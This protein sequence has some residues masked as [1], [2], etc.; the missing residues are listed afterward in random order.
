MKY[1][2]TPET[3]HNQ[4]SMRGGPPGPRAAGVTPGKTG[5][6][7]SDA[8]GA[9]HLGTKECTEERCAEGGGGALWNCFSCFAVLSCPQEPPAPPPPLV[10]VSTPQPGV[11]VM[12]AS[13]ALIRPSGEETMGR[14]CILDS[15]PEAGGCPQ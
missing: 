1:G 8:N 14:S 2:V 15:P 13:R 12:T 9:V 4:G 11:F 5:P 10:V 3:V 6:G 7:N